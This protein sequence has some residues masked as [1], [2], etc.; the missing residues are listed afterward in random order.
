[1]KYEQKKIISLITSA[2]LLSSA[3]VKAEDTMQPVLK[4]VVVTAETMDEPTMVVTDPRTPRQP[5]PAHDGADYLKTIAGF[6]VTRKGGTDGD[7]IFRGMAASRLGILADGENIL[8]GCNSR[9]DAP[10]SYIYPELYDSLT[11]IKGP[12]S[13]QYGPG[14]S[15]AT[16][17]FN[18]DSPRFS[19]LGYRLHASALAASADRRDLL[20]D[21]EAGG[22][23]GYM[24]L[25]GSDSTA[26]DY[27]DGDGNKVHSQYHRYSS[28]VAFGLTP[29]ENTRI[30][31]AA[32][33]SDGEAAY[34]DRAMDGTKFRRDS[35]SIL[36]ERKHISSLVEA[37][38]LRLYESSVNH[39]MDDQ[40]LRKPGKMGYA[41]LAR[42]TDGGRLSTTLALS[43]ASSL[44]VGMDTLNN[45]HSARSA[46]VNHQY[47]PWVDDANFNQYGVFAELNH[48]LDE[49]NRIVTGLR[50]DRWEATDERGKM[51]M[52]SMMPKKMAKNISSGET[53]EQTLG[54]GFAR[55]EHTLN[56]S[57]TT[58]YAGIGHTE[59]FPDYWEMIAKQG[60][61]TASAFDINVE[62]TNQLDVGVMHKTDKL[63]VSLSAF[64]SKVDDFI[65]I[66]YTNKMKMGGVSRNIDATTYGSEL[67]AGYAL[68]ENWK[69]DSSLAWVWGENETDNTALAQLPPLEGRIGLTY[70]R[71]DWSVSGLMRMVDDQDRYDLGRGNII[72]QDLEPDG[73]FTVFSL[74]GSW[75]PTHN[76]LLTA[77]VDN[78]LNKTYG[79]FISRAGGNGMGGAIAGFE[80]TD[81]VNEPGRTLWLKVQMDL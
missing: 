17:M 13:V 75:K 41:N 49:H 4:T 12:Q 32:T 42:D 56:D 20:A 73:G 51:I 65:L 80:Q 79:E 44:K 28:N 24:K 29:D 38:E 48:D 31:V 6:A 8:G 71:D 50:S 22:E 64:Y 67:S 1:M 45:E 66:D 78:L 16:I 63:D 11:V 37:V 7:P 26:N 74:N 39:V 18:R 69:V 68:T 52:T 60:E 15:A 3:A 58:V 27:K 14:N 81:R 43:E 70:S 34:A 10:T 59:R 19:E 46:G 55:I 61:T 36:L 23:W 40:E 2:I 47:S 57:P 54:S 35:H 5:L 33:N 9:M 72:G 76:T 77:G 21:L 62:K 25:T 53:R 30:E